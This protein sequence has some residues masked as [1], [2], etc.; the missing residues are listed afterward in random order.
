VARRAAAPSASH[1]R[2]ALG[3][4]LLTCEHGGNLVPAAYA[5]LFNGHE[6]MLNSHRGWDRGALELAGRLAARLQ[7][8]L[9]VALTSRLVVDLNRSLDNAQVFSPITRPLSEDERRRIVDA[10]YLPYR[11]EVRR[12]IASSTTSGPL[13]H[14]SVHTFTPVLRGERRKVDIGLLFDPRRHFEVRAVRA[15]E[16]NLRS[17]LP[18]L[19]IGRNAPYEGRDDGLTTA[20]RTVFP[21]PA[22]G[23]IELEVNQRLVRR[24][25]EGW[26]ALMD[27]IAGTLAST[28]TALKT[29]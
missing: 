1:A 23:G 25:R 7:A 5:P 21:D 3:S 27:A 11:N 8:P 17:A 26:S 9:R 28:M 10:H 14:V 6:R 20:M 24:R 2:A 16:R 22:Y 15:W 29:L 18:R 4:L 13:V 12:A 19:A